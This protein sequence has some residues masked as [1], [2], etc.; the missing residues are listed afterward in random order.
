MLIMDG[1][2]YYR[3]YLELIA[4]H[5]LSRRQL[6]YGST[7]IDTNGKFCIIHC[8]YILKKKR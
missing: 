6:N 2:K 8:I 7:E 5:R 3:T 1:V 4:R